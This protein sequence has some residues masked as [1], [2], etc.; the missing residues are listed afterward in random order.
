LRKQITLK[1]KPAAN[2]SKKELDS[3]NPT[4]DDSPPIKI[5]KRNITKV[6]QPQL[7][8]IDLSPQGL[9]KLLN[10][11]IKIQSLIRGFL[12]RKNRDHFF[13]TRR[14]ESE[15]SSYKFSPI[16]AL[17][18][19]TSEND[20]SDGFKQ[21]ISQSSLSTDVNDWRNYFTNTELNNAYDKLER[22]SE[23]IQEED[24]QDES[25]SSS[26]PSGDNLDF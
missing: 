5:A 10:G 6:Q 3:V 17:V 1:Q 2:G 24:E 4:I 19:N 21:S 23:H 9:Q 25:G 11:L 13:E 26:D 12:F 15:D 20:S 8:D 14:L 22:V 7:M 16:K 18:K